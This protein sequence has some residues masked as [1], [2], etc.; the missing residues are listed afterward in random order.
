MQIAIPE[1]K[2][3]GGEVHVL[4]WI[5]GNSPGAFVRVAVSAPSCGETRAANFYLYFSSEK[6][7]CARSMLAVTWN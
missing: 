1:R 3:H 5:K 2:V 6:S 7:R 4:H